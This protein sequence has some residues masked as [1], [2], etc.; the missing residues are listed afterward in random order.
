MGL[1]ALIPLAFAARLSFGWGLPMLDGPTL[2]GEQSAWLEGII[3]YRASQ[4]ASINY[5]GSVYDDYL[6][7]S[8]SMFIAPQSHIYGR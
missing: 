5:S 3:Q 4:R 2:P 7:W 6:L 8:S 1:R